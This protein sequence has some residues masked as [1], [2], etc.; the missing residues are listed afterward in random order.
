MPDRYPLTIEQTRQTQQDIDEMTG[1]AEEIAKLMS[2]AYGDSD[3]RTIRAQECHAALQRL[4]WELGRDRSAS[5]EAP[6]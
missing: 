5:A 6:Q 1:R 4:Q 2:A 3:Q